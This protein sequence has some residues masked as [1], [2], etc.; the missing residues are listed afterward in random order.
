MHQ[1][2]G[3][4]HARRRP[5]R[6]SREPRARGQDA[7]GLE[8]VLED[9]AH[10]GHCG[11]ADRH[12]H[13][14]RSPQPTRLTMTAARALGARHPEYETWLALHDVATAA[15]LM[16]V[17]LLQA[18]R[19]AWRARI[20]EAWL[21][22]ACPVCGAWAAVVEARGLERRLRHRC[23]RCGADW[24]AEPVRCSFCDMRDHERLT[25]PVSDR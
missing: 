13:A 1:P 22:A 24:A 2:G 21:D 14:G 3:D 8:P 25:T 6:G 18:C 9:A 15:A 5:G 19:A 20:S 16:A 10:P 12:G 23:G 7:R 17:P 4:A 11:R